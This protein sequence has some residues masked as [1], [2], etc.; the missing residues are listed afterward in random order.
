MSKLIVIAAESDAVTRNGARIVHTVAAS[1]HIKCFHSRAVS[2][3]VLEVLQSNPGVP[4]FFTG[5]G[6]PAFWRGTDKL[7]ALSSLSAPAS[8]FQNRTMFA[9][10]CWTGCHLGVTAA[11]HGAT[12]VGYNKP[13][14]VIPRSPK[15]ARVI[16]GFLG[17][18]LAEVE[19]LG[20][21]GDIDQFETRMG[22]LAGQ[23]K[24]ELFKFMKFRATSTEAAVAMQEWGRDFVV[25][26]QGHTTN[27]SAL[28][29]SLLN[30][31]GCAEAMFEDGVPPP[32]TCASPTTAI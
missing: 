8:V 28:L 9:L 32:A 7:P 22:Q 5:H 6:R 19:T 10:A 14:S 30:R 27:R 11:T 15:T 23:R 1:T 12:Y 25:Y 17:D 26:R 16:S 13:V 21:G 31:G 29:E 20:H 4:V 2:N 24:K 18:L 3:T